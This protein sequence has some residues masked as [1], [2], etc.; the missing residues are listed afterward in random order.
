[1][2]NA[3]PFGQAMT[4]CVPEASEKGQAAILPRD[5]ASA[6]DKSRAKRG[7]FSC[8]EMHAFVPKAQFT[9]YFL[10]REA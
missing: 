3:A 10:R 5:V 1:M 2:P 7:P 8:A 6:A 4:S 9:A